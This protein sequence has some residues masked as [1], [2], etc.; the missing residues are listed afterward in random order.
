MIVTTLKEQQILVKYFVRYCV[1]FKIFSYASD[2]MNALDVNGLTSITINRFAK[3]LA[4][5]QLH[6]YNNSKAS[7]VYK[8]QDA[9]SGAAPP[10]QQQ[11]GLYCV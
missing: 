1:V 8:R 3:L 9:S 5:V 7:T 11:Q 4:V 6:L 2:Y 10:V